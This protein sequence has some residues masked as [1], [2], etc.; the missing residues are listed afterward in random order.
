MKNIVV[1][2]IMYDKFNL[3]YLKIKYNLYLLEDFLTFIFNNYVLC[4]K[5]YRC[6]V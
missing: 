1:K 6:S 2:V 4:L 3:F 5:K